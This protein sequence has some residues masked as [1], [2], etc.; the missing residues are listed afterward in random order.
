MTQTPTDATVVGWT[1]AG[2]FLR[3]M[4]PSLTRI[5]PTS[6]RAETA[7]IRRTKK[8]H[9]G[10]TIGDGSIRTGWLTTSTCMAH[11]ALPYQQVTTAG[12]FIK[13]ASCPR[14]TGA[15]H[16]LITESLW[17]ASTEPAKHLT[18]SCRTPGAP[19]GVTMALSA[20]LSRR[21]MASQA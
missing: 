9:P 7:D 6:L 20:W 16:Q 13:V 19:G 11:L 2:N 10:L 15:L 5:T 1:T 18:G 12:N 21:V 8:S 3:K 17:S 14:P 4:A